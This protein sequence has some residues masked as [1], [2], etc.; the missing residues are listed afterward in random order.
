MNALIVY[1][2]LANKL[3]IYNKLFTYLLTL[4]I[5]KLTQLNYISYNK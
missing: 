2:L 1:S 3:F 5:L 4:I